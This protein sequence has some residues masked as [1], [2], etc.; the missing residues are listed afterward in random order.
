MAI[1]LYLDTNIILDIA[2]TKRST[3][4]ATLKLLENYMAK[5]D[6]LFFINSDTVGTTYFILRSRSKLSR[7]EVLETMYRIE[8]MC[9]I[10]GAT[11]DDIVRALDLCR[12]PSNR[13]DD[14]E[15]ALQFVCA[16]KVEA[17]HI[18][19]NDRAFVSDGI[20]IV[21]PTVSR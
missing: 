6:F 5:G 18:V 13:F 1:R 17:D 12:D 20:D 10:V 8:R 14:Y 4:E 9:D 11:G 7:S 19:T 16:Q 3:S 21:Y 15:D 2:D